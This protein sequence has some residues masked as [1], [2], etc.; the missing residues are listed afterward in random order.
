MVDTLTFGTVDTVPIDSVGTVAVWSLPQTQI[1]RQYNVSVFFDPD[2]TVT[3]RIDLGIKPNS[4]DEPSQNDVFWYEGVEEKSVQSD[5]KGRFDTSVTI[6]FI[7]LYVSSAASAGAE[8]RIS[9]A[10]GRT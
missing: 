2:D 5:G 3:S 10:Y 1:Q 9:A 7:R 4:V 8:A 6:T